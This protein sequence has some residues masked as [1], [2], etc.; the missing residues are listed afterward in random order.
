MNPALSRPCYEA[1]IFDL[2]DTLL[3][4][5]AESH[6][7]LMDL[8][9]RLNLAD[10]SQFAAKATA[11][12][13]EFWLQNPQ[14][15]WCRMLGHSALEGLWCDYSGDD[16]RLCDLANWQPEYLRRVWTS[17]AST[18]PS[19]QLP[20]VEKI[21]QAYRAER[22]RLHPWMPGAKKILA[23]CEKRI[24]VAILTNG[25]SSLQWEKITRSGLLRRFSVIVVSQDYGVGKPRPEIFHH[26][27]ERLGVARERTLM[28]GNNPS[29]DI[30]GANAAGMPSCWLRLDPSY[31]FPA[32]L[33][34]PT[35]TIDNLQE[36][37][38]LLETGSVE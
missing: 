31:N 12:A 8:A 29:S 32:D 38:V 13:R 18:N 5:E 1:V 21:S 37:I 35:H 28:V 17:A 23:W 22:T 4:D 10:A 6:R 9:R 26:T 14:L 3:W 19:T 15:D 27:R 2:D 36:L 34:A 30:A 24:P 7:A 16:P 11:A 20:A 33:P 25:I